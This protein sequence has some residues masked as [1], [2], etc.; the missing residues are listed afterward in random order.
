MNDEDNKNTWTFEVDVGSEEKNQ[1]S[2]LNEQKKTKTAI[3]KKSL[4]AGKTEKHLELDLRRVT[5]IKP[6]MEKKN[7]RR[8]IT[9]IEKIFNVVPISENMIFASLVKRTAAQLIDLFVLFILF[10]LSAYFVPVGIKVC[11]IFMERS[12]LK[13][14]YDMMTTSQLVQLVI[15]TFYVFIIFV[16]FLSITNTTIGKK[17]MRLEVRGSEYYPLS[18]MKA[19]LR[20]LVFKPLSFLTVVGI[21][22]AWVNPEK[23]TFHDLLSSTIVVAKK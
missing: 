8:A 5:P 18:I 22:Y 9:N 21:L 17:I 1:E 11:Q 10:I 6:K 13:F 7:P 2:E 16:V 23:R 19:F 15:F 14:M 20:E 4:A 12:K 3:G